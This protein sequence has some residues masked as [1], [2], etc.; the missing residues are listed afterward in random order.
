MALHALLEAASGD[1]AL[2]RSAVIVSAHPGLESEEDRVMR[3]ASD[4]E[5]AGR[6]LVGEWG[7]FLEAWEGR[8]QTAP[9]GLQEEADW[10]DRCLLQPRRQAVARSFMDW[11][12]G[13][14][15]AL[16]GDLSG[17]TCP[18]L[19]VTGER[20]EKFTQLAGEAV[21]MLASA[22]LQV[23]AESGHRVPW[24]RKEKFLAA[25]DGFLKSS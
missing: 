6:A 16:R 23:I 4:A 8:M 15:A 18:V 20:D 1:D 21:E 17:I 11:S 19:W 10:G 9:L 24:E 12:L 13:K 14:Q 25:V 3:M 5:W 2:F 7:D 22:E